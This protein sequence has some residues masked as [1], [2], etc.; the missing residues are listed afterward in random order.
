MTTITRA[1]RVYG[2]EGHRQRISFHPSVRYDWSKGD[3]TRIVEIQGSD[4]TG[5]NDYARVII[6]RNTAEE[7]EQELEGQLYDGIFE[8]S[9]FGRVEEEKED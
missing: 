4:V 9:R 3:R 1:W 7:C 8:D 2:K 5:T 6:T